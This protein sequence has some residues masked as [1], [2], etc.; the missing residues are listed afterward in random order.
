[1]PVRRD[2]VERAGASSLSVT[3]RMGRG[4]CLASLPHSVV[5]LHSLLV[6][7][8]FHSLSLSRLHPFR[9]RLAGALFAGSAEC[10]ACS[11]LSMICSHFGPVWIY[12]QNSWQRSPRVLLSSFP[13]GQHVS[14]VFCNLK[15]FYGYIRHSSFMDARVQ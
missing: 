6:P 3:I 5:H 7:K 14:L 12:R 8:A 4:P 15:G 2:I 11:T 13:G 1:M 10:F 9:M